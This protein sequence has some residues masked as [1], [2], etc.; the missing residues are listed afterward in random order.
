MYKRVLLK[1]SGSALA[2]GEIGYNA[3]SI[4]HIVKE[5]ENVSKL[6][7]EVG[8]VIGGGN[9]FRG[10]LSQDWGFEREEADKIGMLA[11]IMNSIFLREA[12]LQGEIN[13]VK[14]MSSVKIEGIVEGFE[15]SKAIEYLEK[16]EVVIFAG[17][18]GQPYVTTDYPSI[19]RALEI[20]ADAVFMA[21]NGVDGILN[22]DPRKSVDLQVYKELSY[23]DVINEK[24]KVADMSAFVLAEEFGLPLHVFNFNLNGA[25][26]DLCKGIS[27]GTKITRDGRKIKY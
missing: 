13:R 4:K 25:M 22:G 18:I 12:F 6:G 21:K 7:V 2:S 16:G 23:T 3:N 26:V 8:I 17:G 20:K 1:L 24:L 10:N 14:I 9:L 19:Q 11:T 5:V 27:V 15:R